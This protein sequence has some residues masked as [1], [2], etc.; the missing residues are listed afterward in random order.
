MKNKY[1]VGQEVICNGNPGAITE[2]CVGQLFGM[3]V[4]RL[5]AGEVCVSGQELK[6]RKENPTIVD[7]M[8]NDV[9]FDFNPF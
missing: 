9:D 7:R 2:V 5:D 4:V 8:V 6:D 3:Y 1:E